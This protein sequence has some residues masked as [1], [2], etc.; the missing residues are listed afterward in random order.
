VLRYAV[1]SKD[2]TFNPPIWPS[3]RLPKAVPTIISQPLG[4]FSFEDP[5]FMSNDEPVAPSGIHGTLG[6]RRFQWVEAYYV[7]GPG[8]YRYYFVGINDGGWLQDPLPPLT[9]ALDNYGANIGLF[10]A[11]DQGR[12]QV[13]AFIQRPSVRSYR[14]TAK[15]NTYGATAPYKWVRED[16]F[17]RMVWRRYGSGS[18]PTRRLIGITWWRLVMPDILRRTLDLF[19]GGGD[20]LTKNAG[21]PYQPPR[22]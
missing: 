21:R 8:G 17:F 4:R 2:P 13:E 1:T 9:Q 12:D 15:P 3:E 22:P 14:R 11:P 7:G 5:V 10:N 16:E 6:A 18:P 20:R 19:D